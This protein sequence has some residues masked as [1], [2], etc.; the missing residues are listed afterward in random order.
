MIEEVADGKSSE[1]TSEMVLKKPMEIKAFID[2]YMIGQTD[3]KR[4]MAVAVYNHYKRLLQK[5][6]KDEEDEV[7]I[8]KSNIII[9]NCCRNVYGILFL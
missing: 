2:Q 5:N 6:T 8:E 4:V 3:A 1:L 7:E 9:G